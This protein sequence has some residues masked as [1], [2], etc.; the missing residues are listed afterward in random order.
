MHIFWHTL[1]QTLRRN[2]IYSGVIIA[3][4]ICFS[5]L[6]HMVFFRILA[7]IRKRSVSEQPRLLSLLHRLRAPA[8][9]LTILSAILLALPLVHMDA[10]LVRVGAKS[11]GVAWF[12]ALG[13]LLINSVCIFEE[14]LLSRYDMKAPDNLRARR[15]RTQTQVLRRLAIGFIIIL[16]IGLSLSLF[17]RIWHYGAGLLASAGLASL[18][19]ATAAKSTVS[20]LLAGI[21]IAL[22]EPIRIDDVVVVEGEW[23]RV[24]EITTSYVIVAIWDKRRLVLPLSYFI[25]KPFQNWTRESSD[26]LG[27]AFLYVDYSVPVDGLRRELAAQL[28]SNPLWDRKTCSMQVT[29]LTDRTMEIR[30]LMSARNS[31]ELFDLRCFIRE[32]MIDFIQR[33][34]PEAFPRTRFSSVPEDAGRDLTAAYSSPSEMRNA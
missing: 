4:A 26:L 11:L 16:V 22:T 18:A 25:E 28:E 34:Y 23:G 2:W 1:A 20:N 24:E 17:S 27:T 5:S 6:A 19:L 30:C 3:A 10:W 21:Q 15:V 33:N 32:K 8:R 9:I 7:R 12:C 31:S 29:N 14:L 13:W